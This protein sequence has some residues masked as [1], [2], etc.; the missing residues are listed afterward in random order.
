[1][2]LR[3]LR[4][5][6]LVLAAAALGPVS[7]AL[8]FSGAYVRGDDFPTAW[9]AEALLIRIACP[10]QTQSTG[11]AGDF[12]FCTGKLTVR[13]RGR[14]VASAPFS[15]RTFDSHV[16][17]VKVVRGARSIFQ[18]GRRVRVAW[19]A[20]SHDGQDQWATRTGTV[21]VRNPYSTL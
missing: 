12:S 1:V 8:A 15:I 21:T 5:L 20:R 10:P 13:Y 14:V 9:K 4:I 17:K 6:V 11:R 16:E 18:P 2:T 19:R 7:S 3:C